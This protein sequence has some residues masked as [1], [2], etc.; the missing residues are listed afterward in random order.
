MQQ[1]ED[2]LSNAMLN[3]LLH[4]QLVNS[5]IYVH[6]MVQELVMIHLDMDSNQQHASVKVSALTYIQTKL[7]Y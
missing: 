5:I 7:F 4:P 6:Y 3:G 2:N 1:K